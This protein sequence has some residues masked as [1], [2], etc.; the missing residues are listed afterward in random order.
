MNLAGKSEYERT[1]DETVISDICYCRS[2]F[3]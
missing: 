2:C 1:I 3:F